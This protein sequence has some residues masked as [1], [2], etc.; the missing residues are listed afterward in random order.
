MKRFMVKIEKTEVSLQQIKDKIES[1]G[2]VRC[3]DDE[4]CGFLPSYI[5]TYDNDT[6]TLYRHKVWGY[7]DKPVINLAD[8][9][10]M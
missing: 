7:G 1:L 10:N 6:Y 5:R 3:L 4:D 8:F 2:F 9:L